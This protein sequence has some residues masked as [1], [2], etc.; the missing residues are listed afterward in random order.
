MSDEFSTNSLP[1]I[2][3]VGSI[4]RQDLLAAHEDAVPES[5]Q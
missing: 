5:K 2:T 1:H 3:F 4:D